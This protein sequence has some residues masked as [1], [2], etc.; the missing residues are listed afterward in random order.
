LALPSAVITAFRCPAC[1]REVS[2]GAS[3]L[4]CIAGHV[5]PW[6][7]GYLD[8]TGDQSLFDDTTR[9]TFASFG[10]EWTRFSAVEPEDSVFWQRYFADVNLSS[11]EGRLGLDAGCGK[12]RFSRFTAAHLGALVA[13]D[14]S[15]ATA[16]A[17]ANLADQPNACVIR[18]D[19]RTMPF[20]PGSF[21][22][23]SCL[24]VLHHLPEP[25]AGLDALVRLLSP[26]G[27]LLIYVYSRPERAGLRSIAL[28]GAS[29]L[30]RVTVGMPR[31]ILRPLC[32]PLA[33]ALYGGIVLPGGLGDR[34]RSPRLA[35]MPLATYR[36]QPVRSLWLDTFDRLS[37]PLE[38][39]FAPAEI[40][41]WFAECGLSVRALRTDAKLQGIVA[42]GE[43]RIV[44]DLGTA[45]P[46]HIG[47]AS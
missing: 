27:L 23:I 14:G 38:A 41:S 1:G 39:R 47:R 36:G 6:R 30:R 26:G 4:E 9:R 16:A 12:G 31:G 45:P 8:A 29:A 35:A 32:W 20:H 40:E 43:R 18:S 37:A 2:A 7:D 21:G 25:Q 28:R 15:V 13:S 3:G 19:L 22:F 17:A 46:P 10:Y 24:G 11:L 5:T 42:L 33:V 34:M 44:S